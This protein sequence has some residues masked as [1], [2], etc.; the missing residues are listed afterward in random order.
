MKLKYPPAAT[1]LIAMVIGILVGYMI[2]VL[3]S[4]DDLRSPDRLA[5][6]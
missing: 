5:R 1:I 3:T 2:F 6:V 4:R